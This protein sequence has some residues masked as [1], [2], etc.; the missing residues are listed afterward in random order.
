MGLWLAT[1]EVSTLTVD[2]VP[3]LALDGSSSA[4]PVLPRRRKEGKQGQGTGSVVPYCV[5]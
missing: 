5:P 3:C 2:G 4:V 1:L